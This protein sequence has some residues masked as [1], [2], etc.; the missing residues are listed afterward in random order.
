MP[1]RKSISA[2]ELV[3]EL[4]RNTEYL[5][6]LKTQDARSDVLVA[7]CAADEI[8]LV[9]ELRAVVPR[10]ESVWDF[11]AVGGAPV[12]AVEILVRH[13]NRPHHPRIWEG[14]V[15]ALSSKRARDGALEPLRQLYRTET[16]N[17]RRWLIANAI[18]SMARLAEVRDLEGI[19][20]H[21]ALFRQ[22]RKP[23]H[24]PPAA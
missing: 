2:A 6:Q 24:A 18:G 8:E 7:A 19:E 14:I 16:D 5:A 4:A 21:R 17:D 20:Q 13:L 1:A 3:G 22:S 15:R 9:A 12:V 23:P 11:V 10:L